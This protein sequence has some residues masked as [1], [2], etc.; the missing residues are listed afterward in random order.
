MTWAQTL[1]GRYKDGR[2]KN[3]GARVGAGRPISD[4]QRI[5]LEKH[6]LSE[7]IVKEHRHGQIR[8]VKKTVITAVLDSLSQ[9]AIKHKD[10]RA[11]KLYLDITLG[12]APTKKGNRPRYSKKAQLKAIAYSRV[13]AN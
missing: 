9:Q 5:E 3:G 6:L 4:K 2:R 7:I 12:K 8:S 11:A 10:V 1:R 13:L